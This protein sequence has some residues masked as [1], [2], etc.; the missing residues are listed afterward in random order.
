VILRSSWG[1]R[2]KK[3]RTDVQCD[4]QGCQ[5][6]NIMQC[7]DVFAAQQKAS[8][9]DLAESHAERIFNQYTRYTMS[10]LLRIRDTTVSIEMIYSTS[11]LTTD[12]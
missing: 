5:R 3:G 1:L 9:I 7:R 11:L 2:T 4:Q 12:K 10:V 8:R 6:Y